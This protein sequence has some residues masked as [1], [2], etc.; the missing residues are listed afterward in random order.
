MNRGSTS[1][2]LALLKTYRLL[3]HPK[4]TFQRILNIRISQLISLIKSNGTAIA[5]FEEPYIC[6]DNKYLQPNIPCRNI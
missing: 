5:L 3:Y 6:Y 2:T 4:L 1:V